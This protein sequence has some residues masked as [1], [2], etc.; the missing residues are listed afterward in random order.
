[1]VLFQ[2]VFDLL[3]AQHH[4]E[5]LLVLLARKEHGNQGLH[6]DNGAQGRHNGLCKLAPQHKDLSRILRYRGHAVCV[7]SGGE[8]KGGEGRQDRG[9][10]NAQAR[11]EGST[12]HLDAHGALAQRIQ[13]DWSLNEE[14][15]RQHG[16][17]GGYGDNGQVAGQPP[18]PAQPQLGTIVVIYVGTCGRRHSTQNSRCVAQGPSG[19]IIDLGC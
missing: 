3:H 10:H 7:A 19:E 9:I 11:L 13:K 15:V 4:L 6:A 14:F 12:S 5:V 16:E 18:V 1:M 2:L 17:Y 8:H